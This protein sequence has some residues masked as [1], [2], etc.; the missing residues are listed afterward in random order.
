MKNK[1]RIAAAVV[2][3]AVVVFGIISVVKDKKELTL[4]TNEYDNIRSTYA[5]LQAHMDIYAVP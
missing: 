3:L 4:A 1:I 5:D 2:C